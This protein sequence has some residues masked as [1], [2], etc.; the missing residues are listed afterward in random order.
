MH[1]NLFFSFYWMNFYPKFS[2]NSKRNMWC[3]R[4]PPIT[5]ISLKYSP[6]VEFIELK[7]LQEVFLVFGGVGVQVIFWRN[8]STSAGSSSSTEWRQKPR[9]ENSSMGNSGSK[10]SL[11]PRVGN[12]KSSI[13][14]LCSVY[15]QNNQH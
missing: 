15:L 5:L 11:T 3:L 14:V 10:P 2:T 4:N 12:M 9:L 7:I 6:G 13:A 1:H 8:V